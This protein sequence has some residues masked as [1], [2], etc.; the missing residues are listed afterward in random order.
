MAKIKITLDIRNNSKDRQGK[1][2]LVLRISHASKTR[3]INLDIRL[4]EDQFNPINNQM[5]G[6]Q[7]SVRNS[8]RVQKLY[9]EIDL[10]VDENKAEIKLWTISKLKDE[11]EKRFFN[12]QA[13]TQLLEHSAKLFYRFHAEGQYSTASSY[14]D[15]LKV[16]VKFQMKSQKQDDQCTIKS[17]FDKSKSPFEVKEEFRKYDIPIKAINV[18]YAKDLKAYLSNRYSNKNTVNI[19]LRSLQ[20]ILSDAEKSY[21]ELKGHKPFDSIKK[22]SI[23]NAPVVL[24]PDEISKIRG[25]EFEDGSSKFHVRNYFLFM[26][27][28]MGMNF[29][30]VALAKVSQFDGERFNYTRKK[31][32]REG[33]HFSIMQSEESIRIIN[34]YKRGKQFDEY[35]FPLIPENTPDARIFR[36]KKDKAHWFNKHMKQIA[37]MLKI[38]KKITTYTPRDTWTNLGLEMGI[39]IRKI[40]SGLGHSS[41][42]IT[43]KHYSQMIQN[44]ILD[45]INEMITK[46]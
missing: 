14:E 43:E 34:Y 8:K 21:E 39:D 12:K 44:K 11:I 7:N 10:W 35:L 40:S 2:P 13:D 41:V 18:E 30:D 19:H 4:T 26:F 6:I 9:G 1:S 42:E 15:A 24:S 46:A 33:D 5:S 25:I 28:N 29:F 45:E 23:P 20:S 3:D 17:L 27:N 38:D 36:V 16:L 22:T 37:S 32:E 31:T